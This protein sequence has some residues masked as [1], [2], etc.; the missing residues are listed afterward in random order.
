[1]EEIEVPVEQIQEEI[2][3]HAIHATPQESWFSQVALS[4]A[5]LAAFAAISA[6]LSGHHANEAMI[7]QLKSSD[8]WSHY[9]AKAIKASILSSRLSVLEALGKPVAEKD[10]EKSKQYEDDQAEISAEARKEEAES[11]IHLA[12]HQILARAVTFFQIAITIGAIAILTKRR[13]FFLASLVLGGLGVLFL[14]QSF[15]V[16]VA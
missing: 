9:Q 5:L 14:I 1:M 16:H 2:H 12:T 15:F 6:L 11:K 3:H 10:A 13:R 4:S 7:D 8:H